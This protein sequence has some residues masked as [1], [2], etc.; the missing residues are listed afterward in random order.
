MD[1][2]L[3]RLEAGVWRQVVLSVELSTVG[4]VCVCVCVCA[5]VCVCVCVCACVCVCVCVCVRVCQCGVVS[6]CGAVVVVCGCVR[7]CV[8][9]CVCVVG[10]RDFHVSHLCIAQ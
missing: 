6:W 8:C 1:S 3:L 5:C 9:V 7:V 4:H 2:G 10:Q